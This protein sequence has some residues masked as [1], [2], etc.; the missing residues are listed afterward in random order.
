MRVPVAAPTRMA[1]VEAAAVRDAVDAVLRGPHWILGE[2]VEHFEHA[3]G[4]YVGRPGEHVVGVG[5]G[6]DALVIAFFAVALPAGSTVLV[7]ADD[8]GYAATAARLAG[9]VPRVYDSGDLGPSLADL[10]A[11]ATPDVGAV[12]LTHLHGNAV[13]G[14]ADIAAWCRARGARLVEDC[15]QA[16]GLRV[17]DTHVGLVGDA[18]TFSF[19]PT[20]NLGAVGDAGAVVLADRAVADRARALRQYGWGERQ[21]VALPGGRNSRL[22]ALQA[23]VLGARL[24]FLDARNRRR[25]AIAA[26]YA[27]AVTVLSGPASVHHH[28]VALLDDRDRVAAHLAAAGVDTAVHYP[29]LVTEMPGLE[30]STV[31]TPPTPRAAALVKR[32]LSLPCFPELTD[33]EVDVVASALGSLT[34][35]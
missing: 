12:V 9:L 20:K 24:P 16:H 15:A 25:S 21:R 17:G 31:S 35:R 8:G 19:Y 2:A 33:H 13:E 30:L 3:W 34:L 23:A 4:A 29:W 22:D 10:E 32:K 5:N 14:A 1:P 7:A 11:A 26:R 6:T 18:A 28:A 27:E